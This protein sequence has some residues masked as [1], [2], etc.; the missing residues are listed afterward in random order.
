MSELWDPE[1][2]AGWLCRDI[3]IFSTVGLWHVGLQAEGVP[4]GDAFPDPYCAREARA[5]GSWES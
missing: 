1:M 4:H 5:D 3:L 2:L